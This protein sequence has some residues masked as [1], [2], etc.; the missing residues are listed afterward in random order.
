MAQLANS[1]GVE[2]L[3]LVSHNSAIGF[4]E[5]L[6]LERL[7]E[8]NAFI[9]QMDA[10]LYHLEAVVIEKSLVDDEPENGVFVV[11][12]YKEQSNLIGLPAN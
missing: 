4:Y 12:F 9:W 7:G 8:T 6:G 3:T 11:G 5:K 1:L 2:N 10:M